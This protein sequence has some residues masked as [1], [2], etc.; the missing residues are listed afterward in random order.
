MCIACRY[1]ALYRQ[2]TLWE[3]F[4]LFPEVHY[5]LCNQYLIMLFFAVDLESMNGY[6]HT[7]IEHFMM[8]AILYEFG[9]YIVQNNYLYVIAGVF[10]GSK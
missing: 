5:E 7:R 6:T 8:P 4:A 2:F 3:R 9:L 10:I 1:V